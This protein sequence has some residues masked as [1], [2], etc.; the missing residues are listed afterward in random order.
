[1]NILQ[2]TWRKQSIKI[3]LLYKKNEEIHLFEIQPARMNL[4]ISEKQLLF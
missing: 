2:N 3:S 4:I 1:L